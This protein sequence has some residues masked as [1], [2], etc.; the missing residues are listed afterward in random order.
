M[1]R[2]PMDGVW[3]SLRFQILFTVGV[4]LSSLS[5]RC[6]CTKWIC[7]YQQVSHDHMRTITNID[8]YRTTRQLERNSMIVRRNRR[9]QLSTLL[10]RCQLDVCLSVHRCICV[11]KKKNQLDVTE[12]FIALMIRSTCFGHFYAHHQELETV[13]CYCLWC[14]VLGCWLSGVRCKAAGY[15][16]WK[17]DV[18]RRSR[19]T[20]L[21]LDA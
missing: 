15:V 8:A 21:F 19:A 16:S 1:D 4:L 9:Q 11:E 18:A 10:Y 6:H 13:C 20:S 7:H 17:R 14:A 5:S 12:C 2:I 3:E